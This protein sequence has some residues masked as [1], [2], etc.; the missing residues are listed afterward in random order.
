MPG[1][2]VHRGA[3]A[4][5]LFPAP[6]HDVENLD[7][8]VGLP[9]L[10]ALTIGD[11]VARAH[12]D[13]VERVRFGCGHGDASREPRGRTVA[14]ARDSLPVVARILARI[15][16][17][18]PRLADLF[19]ETDHRHEAGREPREHDAGGQDEFGGVVTL[20]RNTVREAA[21]EL[22]AHH[23]AVALGERMR[24]REDVQVLAVV[25]LVLRTVDGPRQML[26]MQTAGQ[27][28][29]G[30]RG[31]ERIHE[32]HG[33]FARDPMARG[34]ECHR[35]VDA[36]DVGNGR[37]EPSLEILG[38]VVL[39]RLLGGTAAGALAHLIQENDG[40]DQRDGGER[41]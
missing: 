4:V 16:A 29:L 15:H 8:V 38:P 11:G 17:I 35:E 1:V 34:V 25:G 30:E 37:V 5:L 10:G 26:P 14:G 41:K 23:H 39:L 9:H 13:G 22:P 2:V 21:V 6:A 3:V 24:R 19:L 12:A 40:R 18:L 31:V 33:A 28:N 20:A 27:W 32:R 36:R 7:R